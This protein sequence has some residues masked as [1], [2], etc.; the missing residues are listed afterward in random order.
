VTALM[1]GLFAH[2]VTTAGSRQVAGAASGSPSG[3]PSGYPTDDYPTDDDVES[4]TP[5]P[6]P[7]SRDLSSLD[8]A[9]TDD[10]PLTEDQL[11]SER[12]V[13]A[14]DGTSYDLAASGAFS[15]C[16][17]AGGDATAS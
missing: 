6:T 10:T 8:A 11:F 4:P 5:S 14:D 13:T 1:V 15:A 12:T 7:T 9:S 16:G 3:Y 2:V 17:D